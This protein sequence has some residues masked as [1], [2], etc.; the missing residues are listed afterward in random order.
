MSL[1]AG[2]A[3]A[4][5]GALTDSAT[6]VPTP[7]APPGATWAIVSLECRSRYRVGW[8]TDFTAF[9]GIGWCGW[10]SAGG[11]GQHVTVSSAGSKLVGGRTRFGLDAA[12]ACVPFDGAYDWAG[13]SGGGTGPVWR[14][15]RMSALVPLWQLGTTITVGADGRGDWVQT[16]TCTG[17]PPYDVQGRL[18]WSSESWWEGDLRVQLGP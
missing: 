13:A 3:I 1:L 10:T 4:V 16:L 14:T 15:V 5:G 9:E 12:G 7:A 2:I 17:I 18:V 6:T 11:L 8:E